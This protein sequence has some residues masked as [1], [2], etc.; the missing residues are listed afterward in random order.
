M[1][2]SAVDRDSKR[3]GGPVGPAAL[4]APQAGERLTGA[5]PVQTLDGR[6]SSGTGGT[7]PVRTAA[8]EAIQRAADASPRVRQLARSDEMVNGAFPTAPDPSATAPANRT[9][10]PDNLKTG[11]ESLSGISLDDV[12]VYRNSSEPEGLGARAFARGTDIHVG[13]GQEP[14]LPHEA[15]HVVQQK[16]GRVRA[17]TMIDGH[18]VN[19]D[20][21]LEQEAD[22]M[23]GKAAAQL[24]SE[25]FPSTTGEGL[26]RVNRSGTGAPG[27]TVSQRSAVLQMDWYEL[28]GDE[29]ILRKG[30]KPTGYRL[31][32]GRKGPN[33]KGVYETNKQRATHV[34]KP[35]TYDELLG[36][37]PA[38]DSGEEFMVDAELVRFSQDSIAKTFSTGASIQELAGALKRGTAKPADL[39][40]IRVFKSKAGRLVTLDNRRLW[41]CK[42]AG[43]QVKCAWATDEAIENEG[44]KFTS[45]KGHEGKTTITVRN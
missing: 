45:G 9:G 16:Q 20:R 41:C 31:V 36:P 42:T 15:W 23:G 44:F 32:K 25:E 22:R 26:F 17:D 7:A 14:S 28:V 8:L 19:T 38:E 1:A 29:V 10:L 34:Q 27:D 24:R 13:P 2:S 3:A 12:R 6:G 33:G 18:P 35:K 39:P 30:D 4:R 37:V 5:P 43:T 21:S 11:I 40:A